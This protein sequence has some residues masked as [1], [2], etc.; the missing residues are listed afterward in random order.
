LLRARSDEEERDVRRVVLW[1]AV[2][3]AAVLAG[4]ALAAPLGLTAG[5][6][7]GGNTTVVPCDSDGFT[8]SY[9]TSRGKVT[10]VTVGGLASP[11][12]NGGTLRVTVTDA[13]GASTASAG[14]QSIP[15]A[16]TS[17]TLSTS[18]Q[19]SAALVAGVQIAV[20]GP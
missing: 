16:A 3:S 4:S 8:H 19:P 20:E 13:S 11:A 15:A 2:A 1:I 9:T 18:P 6:L 10:A 12:C 5:K 14:P 17:V 7:G